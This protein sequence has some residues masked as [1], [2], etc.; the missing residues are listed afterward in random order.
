MD[1]QEGKHPAKQDPFASLRNAGFA[2]YL[3]GSL[4]SN[5]G[6]Q[7]R[8]V[9][10]GWEVYERTQTALGLGLIG[11]TLALPVLL[12]ALP[13]GAAAD[14]YPR[15]RLIQIAQIGLAA[16]GAGLAWVSYTGAPVALTYLFLLGTGIFRAIGWP[17]SQAIVTGLVPTRVFANA[18]MWRSVAYQIASTLGPLAGGF[19]VAW[20]GPAT[21]YITDA[22]SS[23]VLLGCLFFVIPTPQARSTEKKSW[24]SLI[25][26]AR[27]VRRQ[28]VILSTITLDMVAVLFG[29]ATALLPIYATDVLGVGAEG[30][31]WM[32]AMP[33]LGA[34]AMG[35][36][37]ALLP[38]MRYAG[39]T[40]LL[41][42]VAFGVSTIVFGLST[43][44]PLSLVALF[45]LGAADNISVVVRSTVLQLLTPDEMRGRV[46]AVNAVFIGTS[47]EIGELESGTVASVIGAVPTVVFG[48]V[49]TLLTV[50][51]A[52]WI[53]PPLRRLGALEDLEPPETVPA[54]A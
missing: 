7:M 1:H 22:A 5:A 12:L 2:L 48:G 43:S 38:P 31:G 36:S 52:A 42:V 25:E 44:F 23:L 19:L 27:F 20:H 24:R 41:A 15:K 3:V 46:A 30:F 9:A 14:R 40:L 37:L 6:N 11:L 29:G 32:R 28:P 33:S 16:S 21:V 4:V 50:G 18:T 45:C 51:A 8:V 35:L 34:I 54:P 17:A 26:G 49:M 13:A 47:N 10:V 53:W 39:R